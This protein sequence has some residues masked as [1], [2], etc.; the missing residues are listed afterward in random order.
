MG[1]RLLA[2]V[3]CFLVSVF[4]FGH[5]PLISRVEVTGTDAGMSVSVFAGYTNFSKVNPDVDLD[6]LDAGIRERLKLWDGDERV[7][8]GDA[9]ITVDEADDV[10]IWSAK[11][12]SGI[13]Q[14]SLRGRMFDDDAG[15][16]LLTVWRPGTEPIDVVLD[17]GN[18]EWI[19]ER[20]V[21]A[22]TGQ[23][24]GERVWAFLTQGVEH[25]LSGL[26]HVLF[27]FGLVLLGGS[28]KSLL[29]IATAFT[30]AHSITLTLA[31]LQIVH[32]S[33]RIVEPLIALSIVAVAV[34]NLRHRKLDEDKKQAS[35]GWRPW[36]AFGFGLIH[37]FGF[38]EVLTGL[39]IKGR[40]LVTA[41]VSFNVGVEIGQAAIICVA[42]PLIALAAKRWT[43]TIPKLVVGGS[44]VIGAVGLYWFISRV[45]GF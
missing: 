12:E 42:V 17:R 18:P 39:G 3:C 14:L 44:W 9:E 15:R 20:M 43:A 32:A 35:A 7:E 13:D 8:F 2:V 21:T 11:S 24:F 33:P 41:L 23:G 29:K 1:I 38:A 36:I 19:P 6:D 4:A 40:E 25:I 22:A 31:A 10:V 34:E 26:D 5:D 45:A 37:G 28:L 27:V 30:V 16:T